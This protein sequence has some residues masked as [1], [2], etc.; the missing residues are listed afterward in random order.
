MTDRTALIIGPNGSFGGHAMVALLRHGWKIRAMARDPQSAARRAGHNMPI[1]WV[2]GDA[3]NKDD[4]AAAARGV[5]VIVH[6]ANPPRYQRW[7]Q[8]AIPMLDATIAAARAEGARIVLPGTVYNYAPDAGAMIAEDAPQAPV[9][10]K[11]KVRVEMETALQAASR[12][13][14]KVLVLRAGD[15][16]GPAAPNSGLLWLSTRKAGQVTGVYDTGPEGHGFAYLPDLAETL[17]R[18]LDREADLAD[19]DVFNFRGHWLPT[20]RSLG[21]A[22]RRVT[23]DDRMPIKPFPWWLIYAA[24]PFVT[25]FHELGEMRYLWTRPI[26]LDDTKLRAFIEV[27]E[28]P[29]DGVLRASLADLGVDVSAV[30]TERGRG[31][32]T[33]E[34]ARPYVA[35]HAG[36]HAV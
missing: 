11:G 8:L 29:L 5:Q 28:T 34:G 22:V 36:T 2:A 14:V 6:G 18:L 4:V 35:A 26:G 1:E 32:W 23:G 16:L 19:Y 21:E 27:P 17:A 12:E 20:G 31:S 25:M 13:G 9:T 24:S 15:F 30:A 3:M 7:R 10:R 33:C